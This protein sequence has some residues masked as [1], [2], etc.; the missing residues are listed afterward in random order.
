MIERLSIHNYKCFQHFDW[1][2][3]RVNLLIGRNGVGKSAIQSVLHMLRQF[4]VEDQD[5]QQCLPANALCVFGD[6]GPIDIKV[7]LRLSTGTFTYQLSVGVDRS[8]HNSEVEHES[9][10]WNGEFLCSRNRVQSSVAIGPD[11]EKS[12][13]IPA[14]PAKSVLSFAAH[15]DGVPAVR[16][17]F[18]DL[19]TLHLEPNRIGDQS[20]QASSYL[21]GSG[22]NFVDWWRT[23]QDSPALKSRIQQDLALVL[24]GFSSLTAVPHSAGRESLWLC[25][26][27]FGA[28]GAASRTYSF[29]DL[30]DGQKALIVL[31]CVLHASVKPDA[32]VFLDEPE[33]Y[34]NLFEI[35]PWLFAMIDAA[36][37]NG[38]QLIFSSHHPELLNQLAPSHGYLLERTLDGAAEITKVSDRNFDGSSSTISELVAL[39]EIG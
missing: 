7:E 6:P 18:R 19:V 14:N 12:V 28:T 11:G 24:P 38:A 36:L 13:F 31:Y 2:P 15:V 22:E 27:E 32:I 23:L 20:R 10:Q 25:E 1:S 3:G 17:A 39:G 16:R 9:L 34:L 8:S 26:V 33:N 35:Q 21:A 4:I 29:A 5:L 37:D 30:S